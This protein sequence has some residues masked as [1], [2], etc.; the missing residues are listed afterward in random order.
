MIKST[1]AENVRASRELLGIYHGR[2]KRILIAISGPPGSGKTTLAETLVKELNQVSP[3]PIPHAALIPM[4][5]FHYDNDWLKDRGLNERKGS[6]E[7]FDTSGFCKAIE[8][9]AYSDEISCYPQFDRIQDKVIDNAI[10]IH[11]KTPVI[12]IEGNYLLLNYEPWAQLQRHFDATIFISPEMETL[13]RRLLNRW[14]DNG[15]SHEQ[16][17]LRVQ[18]NDLPNARHVFDYSTQADLFLK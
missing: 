6:P 17:S 4:D 8:R 9:V 7:T 18:H 3:E 1:L 15:L 12:V 14:L 13:Q 16:A 11:P 2:K 10:E 5:G